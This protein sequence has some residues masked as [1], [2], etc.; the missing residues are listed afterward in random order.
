MGLHRAASVP[1]AT[2]P[3]AAALPAATGLAARQGA[4]PTATRATAAAVP[5]ATQS[6]VTSIQPS[7]AAA[8][9][10]GDVPR[11]VPSVGGRGDST[12]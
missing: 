3:E 8:A 12:V 5:A 7:I 1:T 10:R 4:E 2:I 11:L 9:P 6:T